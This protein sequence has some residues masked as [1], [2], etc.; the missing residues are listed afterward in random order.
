MW[1][2]DLEHWSHVDLHIG[3][4]F[5]KFE[6]C[7]P[8]CSWLRIFLP[9]IRYVMMWTWPL[10]LSILI[11]LV[12]RLSHT[13]KLCTKIKHNRT[14]GSRV[15]PIVSLL[16]AI[17]DLTKT[18]FSQLCSLQVR[19]STVHQHTKFKQKS[20]NVWSIY[21]WFDKFS[22]PVFHRAPMS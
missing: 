9:L 13:I 5:T 7:Q 11:F 19:G 10:T 16:S 1:P 4:I 2:N 22:Q 6:V 3:I 15:R 12:Y 17:L 21:Q 8:I 14:V 18:E 20:D